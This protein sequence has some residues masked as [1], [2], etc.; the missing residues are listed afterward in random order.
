MDGEKNKSNL[1]INLSNIYT[2]KELE[3]IKQ[4]TPK[5][6]SLII[7][8][9]AKKVKISNILPQKITKMNQFID[10]EKFVKIILEQI[11]NIFKDEENEILSKS[12]T[13][14]SLFHHP[15]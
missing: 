12:I 4:L 5:L 8:P 3:Q 1:K 11:L 6:S 14:L 13:E 15:F 7:T 2:E 9:N 10:K